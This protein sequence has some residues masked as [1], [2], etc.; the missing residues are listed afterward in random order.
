[1]AIANSGPKYGWVQKV[2]QKTVN[3]DGHIFRDYT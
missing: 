2:D 3:N 1:M